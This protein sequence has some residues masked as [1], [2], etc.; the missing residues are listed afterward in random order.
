MV[1]LAS[2]YLDGLSVGMHTLTVVY[3]DGA[4]STTFEI[5]APHAHSYAEGWSIDAENHWHACECGDTTDKAAHT[6]AWKIDKAA[7]K[8][9]DG[10]KHEEC[11]VCGAKRSENTVIEKLSK[12]GEETPLTPKT[13][14]GSHV[15]RWAVLL[16]VSGGALSGTVLLG[17]KKKDS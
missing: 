7:S 13:G 8:T 16:A 9:E 3:S 10:Q 4:C 14:D 1:T 11:T 15:L 5:K 6:F 17:K 12:S 2:E